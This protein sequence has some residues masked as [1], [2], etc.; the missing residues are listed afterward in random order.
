MQTEQFALHANIEDKHWWFL[1]RRA[2]LNNVVRSLVPPGKR[3]TIVDIGCGTGANIA[4]FSKQYQ[5]VGIDTSQEAIALA[6]SRFPQVDFIEGFAPGSLKDTATEADLFLVTDVIE[7]VRDDFLLLS[8]LMAAS[9]PGAYFV[10]TVPA[11]MSLWSTHDVSFGHFRRYDRKRLQAVWEGLPVQELLLSYYN[12]RLLPIV[13]SLRFIG[14][15]R[16]QAWGENSTDFSLPSYPVNNAL[17]RIFYGESVSLLRC[18]AQN[19]KGLN[20]WTNRGLG[21]SLIAVLQRQEGDVIPRI[22]PPSFIDPYD[23][24]R[25]QDKAA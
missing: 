20:N 4:S 2:I 10:I 24:E 19:R 7:H 11:L 15:L 23:P 18:L 14:R 22:R 21:V 17:R 6:R 9:K 16:G 5:C 1:A 3:K 13:W 8:Q 12:S 25:G